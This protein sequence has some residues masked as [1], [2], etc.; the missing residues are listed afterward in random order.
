MQELGL[1]ERFANPALFESLT[2][3]EKTVAGLVTTLM[4]MGTTFV[5]LILLWGVIALISGIIR[6]SEQKMNGATLESASM[7]TASECEAVKIVN[8]DVPAQTSL[9]AVIAAAVS[10]AENGS[11][12]LR[13]INISRAKQPETEKWTKPKEGVLYKFDSRKLNL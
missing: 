9:I 2:L 6:K 12:N 7:R 3:G 8:A 13:I 11:Q 4:G 1:M 5:I 10:A